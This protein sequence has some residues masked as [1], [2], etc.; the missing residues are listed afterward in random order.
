MVAYL[1]LVLLFV[2]AAV[3]AEPGPDDDVKEGTVV[4]IHARLG[5]ESAFTSG[6]SG[7]KLHTVGVIH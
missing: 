4:N 7:C 5:N 1:S 6:R 2:V 3:L